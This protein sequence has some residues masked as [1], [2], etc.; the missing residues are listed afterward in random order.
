[1]RNADQELLHL[2]ADKARGCRRFQY[3]RQVNEK[4]N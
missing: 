1:M 3:Q 4:G 2:A